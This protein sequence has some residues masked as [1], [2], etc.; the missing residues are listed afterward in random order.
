MRIGKDF[1]L[2][3]KK[4]ETMSCLFLSRTFHEEEGIDEVGPVILVRVINPFPESAHAAVIGGVQCWVHR[5][6]QDGS[7]APVKD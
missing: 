3:T 4:E 2:F 1:I 5:G 7:H 6:L